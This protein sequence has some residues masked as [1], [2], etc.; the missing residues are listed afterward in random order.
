[1]VAGARQLA[2]TLNF[3]IFELVPLNVVRVVFHSGQALSERCFLGFLRKVSLVRSFG[4]FDEIILGFVLP[5][6]LVKVLLQI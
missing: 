3:V 1:M 4:R 2:L 5:A 6:A